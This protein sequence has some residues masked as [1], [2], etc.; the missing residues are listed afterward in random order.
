M[1]QTYKVSLDAARLIEQLSELR[2]IAERRSSL[3]EFRDLFLEIGERL[4]CGL[5]ALRIN[6]KDGAANTGEIVLR[7][8]FSERLLL[9]FSTFR[10]RDRDLQAA[11]QV[12]GGSFHD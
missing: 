9:L 10:A 6:A 4:F 11:G 5:E 7:A 2:D 3:P 1:R 8:E 12:H